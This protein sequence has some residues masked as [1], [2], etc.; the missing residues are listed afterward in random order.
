[1]CLNKGTK[2]VPQSQGADGLFHCIKPC[3]CSMCRAHAHAWRGSL[4]IFRIQH[5]YYDCAGLACR[6]SIRQAPP[7]STCTHV[8]SLEV[9][10]A[11][12]VTAWLPSE[13]VTEHWH[14]LG[15]SDAAQDAHLSI[16]C[17]SCGG[18]S[19]E[20]AISGASSLLQRNVFMWVPCL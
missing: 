4:N 1:M 15:L 16:C 18:S 7:Q 6:Y 10:E 17:Q 19:S 12:S 3:H 2:Q 20:A 9:Q 11:V 13:S 8:C 5:W 14:A